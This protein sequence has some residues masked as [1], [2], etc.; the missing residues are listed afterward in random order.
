MSFI[1][2]HVPHSSLKIPKR[3]LDICIKNR[4]YIRIQNEFLSDY[5]T[6]KL[7]PNKCHKLIFKYSR[8][9]CDV[10]LTFNVLIK[11]K[12]SSIDFSKR[13]IL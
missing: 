3:F 2:F 5:L 1:L 10:S 4:D 8:I 11:G 7:V 6:N 12:Y 9:F 13:L